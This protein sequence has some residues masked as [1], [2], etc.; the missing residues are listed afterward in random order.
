V[1]LALALPLGLTSIGAND[2]AFFILVDLSKRG[3]K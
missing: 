1:A 2:K 3:V